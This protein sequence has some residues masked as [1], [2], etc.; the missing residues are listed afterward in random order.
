MD[1]KTLTEQIGA[2]ITV[3][4]FYQN[5]CRFCDLLAPQ[6]AEAVAATGAKLVKVNLSDCAADD[7]SELLEK[8]D[9]MATP[10][11]VIYA[12][13]VTNQRFSGFLASAAIQAR[14]ESI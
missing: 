5:D 10:T 6:L 12:D 8:F 9:I 14:I 11:V 4:D 13:G 2:G 1:F 3:V 7:K